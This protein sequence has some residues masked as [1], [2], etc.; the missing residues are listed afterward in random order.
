MAGYVPRWY[1]AKN[2]NDDE[3]LGEGKYFNSDD[4]SQ[5]IISGK[6]NFTIRNPYK[7]PVVNDTVDDSYTSSYT[8]KV[9]KSSTSVFSNISKGFSDIGKNFMKFNSTINP[10]SINENDEIFGKKSWS[11]YKTNNPNTPGAIKPIG[12]A[13]E[14]PFRVPL[15]NRITR[16]M[17]GEEGL[18]SNAPVKTYSTDTGNSF[19]NK[20]ADIFGNLAG[21][22]TK[23]KT[24]GAN[25][26]NMLT[27]GDDIGKLAATNIQNKLG[28]TLS[29]KVASSIGRGILD[30]SVGNVAYDMSQNKKLSELP[31]SAL[32]GAAG[33][34]ALM[35]GG[36]F[37]G[38]SLPKILPKVSESV[39]SLRNIGRKT[40]YTPPEEVLSAKGTNTL[41]NISKPN[42]EPPSVIKTPSSSQLEKS[43]PIGSKISYDNSMLGLKKNDPRFSQKG[44]VIGYKTDKWGNE[45]AEIDT[46]VKSRTSSGNVKTMAR[47]EDLKSENNAK[48][49]KPI[50]EAAEEALNPS[51]GATDR[52]NLMVDIVTGNNEE[53]KTLKSAWDNFY[54]RVFDDTD[55]T[56][57]IDER[58]HMLALNSKKANGTVSTILHDDLVNMKGDPILD[59]KGNKIGS[60]KSIAKDIPANE[61]VD[62]LKYVLQKHNIDRAREGKHV[63]PSFSSEQ[64]MK[65]IKLLDQEKPGYKELGD[66]LVKFINAFQEEWAHKSGL[67]SDDLWSQLQNM[68][69]N[70]IPSNREFSELEEGLKK[71]TNGRGFVDQTPP[72][73]KA[74][75]SDRNI[76][77]PIENIANLINKT[78]RTARYNEV[79]QSLVDA[80]KSNPQNKV[81]EIIKGEFN[82]NAG[83]IVSVLVDGKPVNVR[84][85]D[86][87]LLRSLQGLYK[88]TDL[89]ILEK[90]VKIFNNGVKSLITTKNPLFALVN[91]I[92]D[93]QTAYIY[94]SEHNPFKYVLDLLKSGKDITKNSPMYQKYKAIGGEGG[95]FFSSDNAHIT[96]NEL[97]NRKLTTDGNLITGSKPFNPLIKGAKGFVKGIE[98]FNNI[99][100]DTPRLAEF[101]RTLN[102]TGDVQKALYDAGEVTTNFSRGGDV[103]KR[104]D[105]LVMYLNASVQGFDKFARQILT[106]PIPTISKATAIVTVPSVANHL[107][108]R[109]NENY[110]QLD[111]RTKD[112]YYLFPREDG[113]FFKIPKTREFGALFGALAQRI[114]R[115]D[116]GEENAFKDLGTTIKTNF[117]PAN[118]FE[119]NTFKPFFNLESNKDFAGRAIVPQSMLNDNRSKYLQRDENNTIIATGLADAAKKA[120]IDLSPK[121]IDYIV[122]SYTGG[123]A[124]FLQPML[125]E[126]TLKGDKKLEVL[127]APIKKKFTADPIYSNQAITDFYDNMAKA[128]RAASDRNILESID[129]KTKTKEEDRVSA[130]TKA[131]KEINEI[132]KELRKAQSV[133]DTEKIKTLRR[134][135]ADIANKTNKS[136]K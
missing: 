54:T 11:T 21:I 101:K 83:N 29:G 17:T 102:K 48:I 131:N 35:G 91:G 45:W 113:T 40:E 49:N 105:N 120:N 121:Q 107:M 116:E 69:K 31:K 34:A 70:Y 97:M 67:L 14:S 80:I 50:E 22:V 36:K 133:N 73:N 77:N 23:P 26:I 19:L 72:I 103:T 16:A 118:P 98:K 43:F 33:G 82:Q 20:G 95:N 100:E 61:E 115:A 5:K 90:G 32:I 135:M 88:T 25:G 122:K 110:K 47:V 93:T 27:I 112:N 125:T 136:T 106:K 2:T 132:E 1:K 74:T 86:E 4:F 89:Y 60:L 75:G 55:P 59:A 111:N 130:Y 37:I 3:I 84:I 52:K 62:F 41:D 76:L 128:K 126:K 123:V 114:M 79:G 9:S 129:P 117:S 44:T 8:P 6:N 51:I 66:R 99:V 58:T 63:D 39:S 46:G 13:L 109:D 68:Y 104:L 94:G 38:E 127:T 24:M 42:I 96:A 71:A 134:K 15:I 10:S 28:N 12:Y 64:S 7:S 53:K 18:A 65:A 108:N 92:K 57:K 85:N 124:E 119:N 56:K 87:S 30:G 81:A 78:V